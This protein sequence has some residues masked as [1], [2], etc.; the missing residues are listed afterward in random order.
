MDIFNEVGVCPQFNAIYE[1]LTVEEH[2]LFFGRL[3]GFNSVILSEVTDFYIS[4]L[5]LEEYRHQ[6]SGT[7]SGGNKRKLC[8][9][10]SLIGN[11]SLLFLDEPSAGV[12]AISRRYLWNILSS[13]SK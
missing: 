2:L 6:R 5:Q 11:P 8:V 13:S 4:N 7:L 1:N 10:I 3:K 12:D 9:C